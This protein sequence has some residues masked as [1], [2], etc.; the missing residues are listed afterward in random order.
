MSE[1]RIPPRPRADWDETVLHALSMLA[2]QSAAGSGSAEQAQRTGQ[3]D[4][5]PPSNIVGVFAWHPE[6]TQ[7]FFTF[8]RHL[9]RSTLSGRLRELAIVRTGWVRRAEYEWA[10]HVRIARGLGVSDAEIEAISEGPDSELWGPL[11]AAVLR[12]V[13]EMCEERYVSDDTWEQL[14][15]DLDRHQLMDLV[16]TVGAYDLL[17]MAMTT[18]GLELDPDMAGFPTQSSP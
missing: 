11:E 15:A 6:L 8:N 14:S 5:R 18:F 3:T 1:L 10:Q 4:D 2:P 7:S 12:A 16:F 9:F 13:D 17:A